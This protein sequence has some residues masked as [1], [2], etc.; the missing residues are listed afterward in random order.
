[1]RAII[2]LLLSTVLLTACDRT[3]P[4]QLSEGTL[5]P[6]ARPIADFTLVRQDGT[7]FGRRNLE[8]HWSFVFF[9]YTHC[10]DICPT[11]LAMLAQVRKGLE[12][13]LPAQAMPQ[14]I[15][16]SVDPERDTPQQL[17]GFVP[18]F[19]PDFIG[20]TGEP[21]QIRH[22]SRD[23]GIFYEKEKNAPAQDY[24]MFHSAAIALFDPAA[25]YVAVFTPPH[26]PGRIQADF[27]A[28]QDYY[29]ARP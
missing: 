6:E 28:L 7:P 3:A 22:F 29:G 23:V 18:Y 14:V 8:G 25:R 10:P 12:K 26:D 17:A 27:I 5:L 4:P 16:V 13:R 11:S 2:L 15:F 9:G 24:Q 21:E 1:M 19:H 20:L